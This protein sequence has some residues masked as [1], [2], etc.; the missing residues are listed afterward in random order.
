ME[1]VV[2]FIGHKHCE[3]IVDSSQRHLVPDIRKTAQ[4]RV[5]LS[6]VLAGHGLGIRPMPWCEP[7]VV[8]VDCVAMALIRRS[9]LQTIRASLVYWQRKI[10]CTV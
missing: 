6:I 8:L 4:G 5:S 1:R 2:G 9:S 3:V 10:P 7:R